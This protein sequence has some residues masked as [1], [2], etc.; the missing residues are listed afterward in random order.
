MDR[1]VIYCRVSTEEERQLN[2]LERQIE[3]LKLCTISN[4]WSLVDQ[5]VDEGKTGTMTK[6]RDEYKRLFQDLETNHFDIIVIKSQDRLMRSTKDWYLFVD[7]LV[8]NH[9]RLFFYLDNKF[10]TPDDALITGIKAIL[11]EEYS[12]DLSKKINNAHYHRQQNKGTVLLTSKTW[13][14]D[15]VGKDVVINEKESEIVRLMFQMCA[16]G[17]GSRSI[18]KTLTNRG[19]FSR[20]GNPFNDSTIRRIIRNP[21]FKGTAV[22]NREHFDFNTKRSIRNDEDKWI[23]KEN[24]VPAIV[25]EELWEKANAEMDRKTKVN[26]SAENMSKK[27][28][29]K[30]GNHPL[31][32]K[33]ICGECGSVFWRTRYKKSNGAQVINWCCC[34]YVRNGRRTPDPHRTTKA[35]KIKAENRG[36]DNIH[37][38]NDMLEEV[39]S[40]VAEHFY[41]NKENL[42][43]KAVS[44]LR[45]VLQ[46][47][48]DN[49]LNILQD[50][51]SVSKEKRTKLLD[52]YL[53]D[54]IDEDVYKSKDAELAK[55]IM[56]LESDINIE[57]L[58]QNEFKGIDSRINSIQQEIGCIINDELALNFIYQ[59]ISSI[60]VFADRLV[61]DYDIF[62]QTTVQITKINYRKT[63]FSV[64]AYS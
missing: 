31:S 49:K 7:R 1:A 63:I 13:G 56:K 23:Y 27:R 36:C 17:F 8:Q 64:C 22:M 39:L 25:D 61:I 3:E 48:D 34:E 24:G 51:L 21:L 4:E 33:M 38:N 58:R 2:A 42:L 28:G 16:D 18:A 19:I 40:D 41:K 46:S 30:I 37:I 50:E 47:T 55:Q 29:V 32:S 6:K 11:A 9:K 43:D 54:I 20:S 14:Y 53:D 52:K 59:H 44:I 26:H 60:K 57:K 62:P 35:L 5:Y 10:Y 15:K 12:R 45:N